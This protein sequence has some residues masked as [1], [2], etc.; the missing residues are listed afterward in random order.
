MNLHRKQKNGLNI[1][2]YAVVHV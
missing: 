1:W 2:H